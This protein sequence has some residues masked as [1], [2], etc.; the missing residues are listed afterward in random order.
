MELGSS[1]MRW[2]VALAA[3]AAFAAGALV[4]LN[5]TSTASGPESPA[6]QSAAEAA[7]APPPAVAA[8]EAADYRI[9]AN[10]R[11]TIEASALPAEGS[12]SLALAL[13]DD[14]RDAEPRPVR[15]V[16]GDG[17]QI[18]T[19]AFD[20]AGSGSGV[21]LAIDATWLAPG[22]YLIEVKTAERKPLPLRRYVLE[23]K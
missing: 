22:R 15:I 10:G 11:L 8:L 5:E 23:V 7:S 1:R 14:A 20:L 16:A 17:R 6:L 4:A 21:Q 9:E 19:R 13:P 3:L 2:G 18:E 12:L